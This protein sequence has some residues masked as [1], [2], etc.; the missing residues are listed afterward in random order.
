M[1]KPGIWVTIVIMVA[2]VITC[3]IV[4]GLLADMMCQYV[5]CW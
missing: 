3:A 5:S 1:F 2:L 4:G